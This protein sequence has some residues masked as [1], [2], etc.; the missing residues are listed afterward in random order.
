MD[1]ENFQLF[2]VEQVFSEF[3]LAVL[4]SFFQSASS[5]DALPTLDL[6]LRL[7]R[8]LHVG[9]FRLRSGNVTTPPNGCHL[10]TLPPD[11]TRS[12]G[13]GLKECAVSCHQ[14]CRLPT[15]SKL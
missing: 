9:D 6:L 7:L 12:V 10:A 8:T 1:W 13:F 14:C 5:S 4:T 11:D 15:N 3:P 2:A